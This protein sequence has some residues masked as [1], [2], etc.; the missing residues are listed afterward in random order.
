M[1]PQGNFRN[2]HLR[3]EDADAVTVDSRGDLLVTRA[4]KELRF[5][6]PLIY[7]GSGSQRSVVDGGFKVSARDV[8]FWVGQYDAA[9]ALVIDPVLDYST[10]FNGT[11]TGV[12]VD[13]NGDI[14]ITG[15]TAGGLPLQAPYQPSAQNYPQFPQRRLLLLLL[16][17]TQLFFYSH[18]S[19]LLPKSGRNGAASGE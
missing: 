19:G 4:S 12:A 16:A 9:K 1:Q 3:F 7:Q 2:I 13:Q 5:K 6:R 17:H 8:G 14:V 15:Q 11:T 10:L 18:Q